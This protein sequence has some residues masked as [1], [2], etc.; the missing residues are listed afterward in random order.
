MVI[1]LLCSAAHETA[2]NTQFQMQTSQLTSEDR[3]TSVAAKTERAY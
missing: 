1:D 3:G 2:L